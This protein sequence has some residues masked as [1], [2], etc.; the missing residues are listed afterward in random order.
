LQNWE[1]AAALER[2]AGLLA[3]KGENDFKVRAYSQAARQVIRLSEPLAVLIDEGR[4]DQLPGIGKALKTKIEELVATGQSI[5][6][7]RL[8][9][10]VPPELLALYAIP[11]IGY[12]TAAVLVQ[13][14][15]LSNMAEL[16]QAARAGR[17]R[18]LPGLGSALEKN[19][20]GYFQ[21]RSREPELFHRGVAVPL[22]G[23]LQNF[24]EGLSP[25]RF[26]RTAGEVRRGTETVSAVLGVVVLNRND[27]LEKLIRAL[28]ELPWVTSVNPA[29]QDEGEGTLR[30]QTLY[31]LP[32]SIHTVL[33]E[34]FPAALMRLTG[35]AGH[36][37]RLAALA[38]QGGFVLTGGGLR[39]AGGR[40][41]FLRTEDDLYRALGL[42]SIPPE[43][44]EDHGEVEAAL[45]GRLPAVLEQ[46]QI[47]GDLH[48]HSDWSDG[49]ASLEEIASAA[50]AMGYA[51]A[52]I[53]DHSPGLRI[54]GGLSPEKLRLQ[55]DTIRRLNET[56]SGCYLFSGM[57]VNINSDG[58]LDLP[59][60][61]L[62]ELELVIAS[63][64]SNFRQSREEMT[65]RLCRA[66]EHPLVHII[67]HPTG[68]LLGSR[69]GYQVDEEALI[70]Q[71]AATGTILEI[72]ASP[73]RLD[74]PEAYIRRARDAGVR[75][76]VNTDAHSIA[77]MEDMP[78]GVTAARRGWLEAGDLVNTLSLA[79]LRELLQQKRL[80]RKG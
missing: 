66:M 51:Y 57:E 48:L 11:G 27:S 38:R 14:L 4:L 60:H 32:V 36:W 30:L 3:L 35:S 43:L 55:I 72:N 73:Q 45:S 16:E 2:M 77:T 12:K 37:E 63:V 40:Q 23:Q 8:E 7:S 80:S 13:G 34:A 68:R 54:A 61:L 65:A 56:N 71:A 21:G 31:G 19:I 41:L 1:V 53:T 28:R 15:H 5:F 33:E 10:E 9:N 70:R 46:D 49:T 74:L 20:I 47:R 59:D 39:D 24:L 76:A 64:H 62:G 25:V 75:L 44:R 22:A 52:A 78:Y 79:E 58:S 6:L 67:G 42:P 26:Y 18:K 17:V 50:S 69:G 29:G